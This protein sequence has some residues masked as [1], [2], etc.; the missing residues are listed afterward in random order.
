MTTDV[1]AQLG[2]RTIRLT[3]NDGKTWEASLELFQLYLD[4]PDDHG[5]MDL[6]LNASHH[7]MHPPGTQV[8]RVRP[9]CMEDC[10]RVIQKVELV[11]EPSIKAGETFRGATAQ[12]PIVGFRREIDPE[13]GAVKVSGDKI[14]LLQHHNAYFLVYGNTTD[15]RRLVDENGTPHLSEIQGP[16]ML[17]DFVSREVEGEKLFLKIKGNYADCLLFT[18]YNVVAKVEKNLTDPK[19]GFNEIKDSIVKAYT[20][21]TGF[22]SGA[23]LSA[24]A[25]SDKNSSSIAVDVDHEATVLDIDPI[26]SNCFNVS[27]P[28]DYFGGVL[29]Q[30]YL[31]EWNKSEMKFEYLGQDGRV[32]GYDG[33]AWDGEEGELGENVT[34]S[35]LRSFGIEL[36]GVLYDPGGITGW[37]RAP[38]SEDLLSISV[39]ESYY[40][41]GAHTNESNHLLKDQGGTSGGYYDL[42]HNNPG[43]HFVLAKT[44]AAD[45]PGL[46]GGYLINGKPEDLGEDDIGDVMIK[47]EP[48]PDKFKVPLVEEESRRLMAFSRNSDK[49]G[50]IRTAL[51]PSFSFK[52]KTDPDGVTGVDGNPLKVKAALL[53]RERPI[54]P[55]DLVNL[56]VTTQSSG[57]E[58]I[59]KALLDTTV[60][61]GVDIISGLILNVAT[62]GTEGALCGADFIGDV[63]SSLINGTLNVINASMIEPYGADASHVMFANGVLHDGQSVGYGD[64]SIQVSASDFIEGEGEKFWTRKW[65]ISD[66]TTVGLCAIFK[67]P[68]NRLKDLIKD[69]FSVEDLGGNGSAE[70]WGMKAMVLGVPVRPEGA[71]QEQTRPYNVQFSFSRVVDIL[72]EEKWAHELSEYQYFNEDADNMSD[73]DLIRDAIEKATNP[74]YSEH[75]EEAKLLLKKLAIQAVHRGT[76]GNNKYEDYKLRYAKLPL[77]EGV[78]IPGVDLG[79]G[80]KIPYFELTVGEEIPF[81]AASVVTVSRSNQ[82]AGARAAILSNGFEMRL[83]KAFIPSL[84]P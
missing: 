8:F 72:P 12:S 31:N 17:P 3:F 13:K 15:R 59:W 74:A 80:T 60:D 23:L 18:A 71:G 36:D 1:N 52:I 83:I 5:G 50:P 68:F 39:V 48:K 79:N 73:M 44:P 25:N 42:D 21:Y 9:E 64:L 62:A 32:H 81:S 54:D 77:L 33:E 61:L 11:L 67:E 46:H 82:N 29:D 30:Y 76:S 41:D 51:R 69:S 2:P 35:T 47:R 26:R 40:V 55:Q 7:N 37:D 22:P 20:G 70:A 65:K 49:K 27:V 57:S 45:F 58:G 14:D 56:L 63:S 19:L 78:V 75:V 10:D 84:E 24:C 4:K 38:N 6:A 53:V 43:R 28:F 66:V 16:D 34:G